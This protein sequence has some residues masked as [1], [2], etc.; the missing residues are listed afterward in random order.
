MTLDF[1]SDSELLMSGSKHG[2]I[3]VFKQLR[4]KLADLS[5]TQISM[6]M[7]D[8]WLGQCIRC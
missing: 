1:A 3:K 8:S 6:W 2:K 7:Y 4:I 5:L